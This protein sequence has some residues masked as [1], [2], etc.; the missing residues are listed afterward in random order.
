MQDSC[1]A[2]ASAIFLKYKKELQTKCLINK[3]LNLELYGTNQEIK[4]FPPIPLDESY[5]TAYVAIRGIPLNIHN[6]YESAI[7]DLFNYQCHFLSEIN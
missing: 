2:D 6:V 7:F 1:N 3:T 4:S 5:A